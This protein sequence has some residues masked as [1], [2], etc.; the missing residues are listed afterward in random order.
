MGQ[1][2]RA[3]HGLFDQ[4]RLV[5]PLVPPAGW[6]VG[7]RGEKMWIALRSHLDGVAFAA[8]GREWGM[9][10]ERARNLAYLGLAEWRRLGERD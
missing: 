10:R 8:L 2:G 9:S 7:D 3:A 1:Y 4:L 6:P 5:L